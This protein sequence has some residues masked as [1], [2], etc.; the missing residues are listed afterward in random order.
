M[1]L[2]WRI[3][4]AMVATAVAVLVI[5]GITLTGNGLVGKIMTLL[6]VALIMGVINAVV[7]PFTQVVS[8]VV[9]LLTMGLFLLVI[10]ALMLLLVSWICG[11]LQV[12][13][14]VNGFWSALFGSIII[15]LVSALIGSMVVQRRANRRLEY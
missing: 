14:H 3:V 15:S 7:K 2:F 5:P 8:F 10:N 13:F 9:I 11:Q 4:A 12:G 6:I 1:T